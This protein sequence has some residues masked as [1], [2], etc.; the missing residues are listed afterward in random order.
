MTNYEYDVLRNLLRHPTYLTK[1]QKDRFEVLFSTCGPGYQ[2]FPRDYE[3]MER[4]WKEI[5]RK[6]IKIPRRAVKMPKV[7]MRH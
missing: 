5:F 7:R 2:P 4:A 3:D 6:T 1:R